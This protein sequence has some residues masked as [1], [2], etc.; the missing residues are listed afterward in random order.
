LLKAVLSEIKGIEL[1]N[2]PAYILKWV[3][4]EKRSEG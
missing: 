3:D 2:C 4:R 1:R